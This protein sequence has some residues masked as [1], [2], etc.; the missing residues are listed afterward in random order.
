MLTQEQARALNVEQHALEAAELRQMDAQKKI[1]NYTDMLNK[2]REQADSYTPEQKAKIAELMPQISEWYENAKAERAQAED[3]YWQHLNKINEYR[4]LDAAQQAQPTQGWGQRRRT[5][6]VEKYQRPKIRLNLSEWRDKTPVNYVPTWTATDAAYGWQNGIA[7][8]MWNNLVY[9][10]L[11][12]SSWIDN[13]IW[14]ISDSEYEQNK[15][16]MRE[17]WAQ[18]YNDNPN[19]NKDSKAYIYAN[20]WAQALWDLARD[21]DA[22]AMVTPN[23]TTV[24]Y[25]GPYELGYRYIPKG[26]LGSNSTALPYNMPAY[27][28]SLPYTY[29]VLVR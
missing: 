26:A 11:T 17:I 21:M 28:G 18:A 9:P 22:A 23:V 13:Q 15:K 5:Y 29:W 24:P 3:S 2:V 27:N 14:L 4:A 10:Y 7:S 20:E 6:N 1:D 8:W 12:A 16:T 19:V 25:N